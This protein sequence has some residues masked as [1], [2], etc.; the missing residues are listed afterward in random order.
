MTEVKTPAKVSICIPCHNQF[1]FL[2]EAIDSCMGQNYDNLE[3]IILDDASTD[4]IKEKF[5]HWHIKIKHYRSEEPSGSGGAFNKA[6]SYATGD[7]ILLLCADD[8]LTD[9]KLISDI[10]N[11]FDNNPRLGHI[12][13]Y[14][15]QFMDGDD[16]PVRAWRCNDVHELANNPSGLAF[17]REAI[18]GLELSNKMFVEAVTLVNEVIKSWGACVLSWDTVAVRIHASTARSKDYYQKRWVSSPIEEWHNAGG[19]ALLYDFTSLVQIKNYFTTAAV[20]KECV[21]FVKLRPF[22]IIEPGFWFFAIISILTPRFILLRVP[23]IYRKTIGRWTTR[24][25]KR[26]G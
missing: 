4:T 22:N 25:I 8:L 13:R 3:I 1:N 20:I 15:Y 23:D 21:N 18:K 6:I 14:Y 7:Y 9:Q 2:M 12:S 19:A 16:R 11:I 26:Q 5:Q 17:R 10:V 24:K